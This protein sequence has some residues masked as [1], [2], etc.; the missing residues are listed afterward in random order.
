MLKEITK[1]VSCR[2][3][4]LGLEVVLMVVFV[5]FLRVNDMISKI[6]LQ[7]VVLISNYLLS[8]L[9]VFVKKTSE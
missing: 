9:F 3:L 8:K 5:S 1:F 7:V 4:T 2:L 6:I